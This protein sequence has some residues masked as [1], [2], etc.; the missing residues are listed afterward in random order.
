MLNK[1]FITL[2]SSQMIEAKTHLH[3][4]KSTGN[5]FHP[6]K[7]TTN[8]F[9]APKSVDLSTIPD[10]TTHSNTL[11]FSNHMNEYIEMLNKRRLWDAITLERE[12]I[13]NVRKL[14]FNNLFSL[15]KIKTLNFYMIITSF[16]CWCR[17][18]RWSTLM[19]PRASVVEGGRSLDMLLT[20]TPKQD[21][22]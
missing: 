12:I 19:H 7:M 20:S 5:K 6:L 14:C 21:W 1:F 3:P 8:Q 17:D 4:L 2:I 15:N 22:L 11:S 13:L 9:F 16:L 18:Y 10:V